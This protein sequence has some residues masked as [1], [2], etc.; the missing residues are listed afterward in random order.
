MV[1]WMF[2]LKRLD[3]SQASISIYLL[4]FLG[5]LIS[6]VTLKEKVTTTMAVGGLVT[7]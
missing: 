1:L 4:P 2:L 3:V 5:V 7:M 6:A